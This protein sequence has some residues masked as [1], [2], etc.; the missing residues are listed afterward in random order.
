[1]A[2]SGQYC[3][4]WPVPSVTLAGAF[5]LP[6]FSR[7]FS[8]IVGDGGWVFTPHTHLCPEIPSPFS[9]SGGT[10]RGG[11]GKG[12]LLAP[13]PH[14]H[15]SPHPSHGDSSV[16]QESGSATELSGRSREFPVMASSGFYPSVPSYHPGKPLQ[17]TSGAG[18]QGSQN[19]RAAE[20]GWGSRQSCFPRAG[21]C[22]LPD[23][24]CRPFL[25]EPMVVGRE[26]RPGSREGT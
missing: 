6:G 1:M 10:G 11:R 19:P 18:G 5:P 9:L 26:P 14:G 23:G 3:R 24:G 2:P 8:H 4:D 22:S 17:V 7:F 25:H 15:R 16:S 20:W 12:S 13:N 21:L